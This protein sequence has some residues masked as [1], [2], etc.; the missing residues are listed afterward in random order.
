MKLSEPCTSW[1]QAE[2]ASSSQKEFMDASL[3]KSGSETL[4]LGTVTST[5]GCSSLGLRNH[6][7]WIQSLAADL[8]IEFSQRILPHLQ[9]HPVSPLRAEA[10]KQRAWQAGAAAA[11]T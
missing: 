6:G 2:A 5:S 7:V 10:A 11:H 3:W 4:P 1:A 9:Q 8:N